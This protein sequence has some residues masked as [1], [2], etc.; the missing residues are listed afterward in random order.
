M[1]SPSLDD[2]PDMPPGEPVDEAIDRDL[3]L[4]FGTNGVEQRSHA[5]MISDGTPADRG[6]YGVGQGVQPG[7]QAMG[8]RAESIDGRR[9]G[10]GTCDPAPIVRAAM[11]G[12]AS[13]WEHLVKMY[14][15]RVY[16]AAASRLGDRDAAEEVAQS[17]MVTVFEHIS[18]GRYVERGQFE[19]WLFRVAM[20]R[21]RDAVRRRTRARGQ[22]LRLAREGGVAPDRD[23]G[24]TN[25]LGRAREA[26]AGLPEAD[27]EIIS[28]RHHGGLSFA[29][30][31]EMM[32]EPLGTV[33]A[34]HH[35]ALKKL[36]ETLVARGSMP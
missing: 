6:Q 25:D 5:A 13:A 22:I 32:G 24:P 30:I 7:M 34:R 11:D 3:V 15:R 35:R 16:A 18:S 26:I 21:V 36:R 17:V 10:D 8:S 29:S 23:D 4:G 33:L 20:N 2:L 14:A 9:E 12:S 28:L 1:N 31:A 27:R 19:S